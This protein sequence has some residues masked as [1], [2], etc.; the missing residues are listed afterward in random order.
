MRWT[1]T[2]IRT[3]REPSRPLAERA[4]YVPVSGSFLAERCRAKY[5]ETGD[6]RRILAAA[7][8][9]WR[10]QA[11]GEAGSTLF[12]E[13]AAAAPADAGAPEL[14]ETP[15]VHTIAQLAAFTGL[16]KEALVKSVVVMAGTQPVLCLVRGDHQLDDAKLAR[17]L[18]VTA[19]VRDATP[20][21]IHALFA[22]D[23]GS[24]GPVGVSSSVR[25]F[26]DYALAG[27]QGLVTGA[28]RNGW[29]LRH[30]TPGRDFQCEFAAIRRGG[31]T[32]PLAQRGELCLEQ[33]LTAAIERNQDADGVALPALLTPFTVVVTPVHWA[34]ATQ[35]EASET[36]YAAV[37]ALGIGVLLDDRD[38]RPGVKFKDADLI[39]FP[40]RVTVGKKAV[41]GIVEMVTRKPRT[42]RDVPV[43]EAA[44]TIRRIMENGH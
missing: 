31:A 20:D 10:E 34:D 38:E 36:I 17:A 1:E 19:D 30:V 16:P 41:D 3:L 26:A 8:L 27:L 2:T 29:H 11:E 14:F 23:P 43:T 40:F 5:A 12:V 21:Q 18:A 15:D 7:G 24:L 37:A 33:F 4:G 32:R 9:D 25:I 28:N 44:E 42:N 39:G 22:A 6:I 13:G 35:R